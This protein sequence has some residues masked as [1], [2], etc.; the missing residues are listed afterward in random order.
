VSELSGTVRRQ[1][2]TVHAPV[3][4]GAAGATNGSGGCGGSSWWRWCA[5]TAGSS[6]RPGAHRGGDHGHDDASVARTRGR[7]EGRNF[8]ERGGGRRGSFTLPRRHDARGVRPARLPRRRRH[9]DA[10]GAAE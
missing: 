7:K 2:R 9:R 10:R 4:K 6:S 5:Q 3:K 8:I 1:L